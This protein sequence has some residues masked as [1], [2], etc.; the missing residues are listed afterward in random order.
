MLILPAIDIRGGKCVR[1]LQ[2]DYDRETVFGDDP[3]AMAARWISEGAQAL[4]IVDLDGARQGNSANREAV[5][6]ILGVVEEAV[7]AADTSGAQSGFVTELGGGI[8]D[9]ASI[10]EW[11]G[12][13]L[14]RVILG[15][16]AVSDP[17]LVNAAAEKY[18][19]RVWLGIDARGGKVAVSGWL[20]GTE[21]DA[22][23]FAR[24]MSGRGV[25]GIIYTD[26]ER[27]G[28]GAGLNVEATAR[29]A[30]AVDVPVIA[31]GGVD[32]I[33]DVER[34]KAAAAS[35]ISGIIVGRALYDGRVE[36]G[37]MIEAAAQS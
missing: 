18:P 1:L 32:S 10:D 7:G 17:D 13:G 8:R 21:L 5:R 4:H 23:D 2:G 25:A 20:E 33:A 15:T 30:A 27:D 12:T 16:A 37:P 34:V 24:D 14:G 28:T 26:I 11:L 9:L 3:A 19:G 29:L 31:S 35:G 6:A 22:V 36:L